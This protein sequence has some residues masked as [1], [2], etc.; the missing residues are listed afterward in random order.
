MDCNHTVPIRSAGVIAQR[1]CDRNIGFLNDIVAVPWN[2]E[3][4]GLAERLPAVTAYGHAVGSWRAISFHAVDYEL[5]DGGAEEVA[6]LDGGICV[7]DVRN[8]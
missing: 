4:D 2:H 6:S 5:V 3:F 8:K 7:L 1:D